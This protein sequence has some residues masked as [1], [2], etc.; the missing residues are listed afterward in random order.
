MGDKNLFKEIRIS[1]LWEIFIRHIIPIV[2]AMVI[3]VALMFACNTFIMDP[4]YSSTSTLYILKQ[5]RQDDY[6]DQ[7]DFNLALDVVNDCS[8]LIKSHE[9]LDRVIKDLKLGIK[10][11]ELYD[12][13]SVS[14][15]AGTRVLEVTVQSETPRQ[16]KLIVDHV[17]QIAE[18]RINRTMGIDQLHIYSK[19]VSSEVRSNGFG[20]K[21]YALGGIAA[22][23]IVY[24]VYLLMFMQDDK[25]RTSEDIEK[26]LGLGV[27]GEIPNIN[28]VKHGRIKYG[29]EYVSGSRNLSL[30]SA[31][32]KR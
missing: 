6:N 19:G 22:A 11:K 30:K 3:C 7:S 17:C 24:A 16:A 21:L 32:N 10:Y 26:Y 8:Y 28:E 4:E 13:I 25:V 29:A 14:N 12:K 15:P 31:R 9:V 1:D 23:V 18:N 2:L 20:I 27:L 5:D